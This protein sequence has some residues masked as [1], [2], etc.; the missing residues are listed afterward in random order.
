MYT[1][2]SDGACSGNPGPGGYGYLLKSPDGAIHTGSEGYIQTT[3]NRMELRG[4]IAGLTVIPKD[5]HVKVVTDSEYVVNAFTKGWLTS[6][7]MRGWKTAAKKP[8]ANRD[9]WEQLLILT[10]ERKVIFT[11]IRGHAGHAENEQ[12][13]QMAVAASQQSEKKDDA[14]VSKSDGLF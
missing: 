3:N 11:W 9:L 7:Q 14:I 8:V 12:C 2:Y 5:S 1:L 13:D 10:S 4:I 6:W